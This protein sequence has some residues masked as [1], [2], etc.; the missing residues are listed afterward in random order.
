[1]TRSRMTALLSP[2]SVQPVSRTA[3]ALSQ[4]EYRYGRAKDR[5]SCPDSAL[6]CPHEQ[7][8]ARVGW[9]VPQG[10]RIHGSHQ[11]EAGRITNRHFRTGNGDGTV[12]QR[13][14]ENLQH[15]PTEFRQLIEK[16]RHCAPAKS[17]PAQGRRLRQSAPHQKWY[18]E[19]N[20]TGVAVISDVS[21]LSIPPP[22]VFWWFQAPSRN[23]SGR[24]YGRYS[25]CQHR[26]S[27]TRRGQSL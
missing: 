8:Q 26:F 7:V 1:M 17:R 6:H 21:S 27:G 20:G 25:F 19:A 11:H 18:G 15:P 5:K 13:L 10:Q 9:F 16:Q 14:A 2:T 12:F 23:D 22:N 24:Q 3:Q 4:S